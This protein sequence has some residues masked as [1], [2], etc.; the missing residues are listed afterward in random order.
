MLKC[1]QLSGSS[2]ALGAKLFNFVLERVKLFE[3]ES[4][5][6]KNYKK[7]AQLKLD[8]LYFGVKYFG[9]SSINYEEQQS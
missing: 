6:K 3:I 8:V 2:E 5:D 1:E 9:V 4:K 7:V